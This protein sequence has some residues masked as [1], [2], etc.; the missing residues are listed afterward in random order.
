MRVGGVFVNGYPPL[1]AIYFVLRH[2]GYP[3]QILGEQ[4]FMRV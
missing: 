2:F 3:E 1:L 4:A